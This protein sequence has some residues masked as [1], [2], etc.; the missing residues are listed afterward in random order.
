MNH[1]QW[2]DWL[3]VYLRMV[4]RSSFITIKGYKRTLLILSAIG[5]L[6][7]APKPA[8]ADTQPNFGNFGIT[9][10][11]QRFF[12]EGRE[13]METE[14]R[15]LQDEEPATQNLLTIDDDVY[16]QNDLQHLEMQRLESPGCRSEEIPSD[17]ISPCPSNSG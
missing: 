10:P 5:A 1:S 17:L 13:Q 16:I 7:T 6:L 9:T 11:S 8:Q 2:N 14:S 3:S 4:N 15:H 12:E